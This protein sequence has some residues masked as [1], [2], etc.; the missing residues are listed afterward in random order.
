MGAVTWRRITHA[1]LQARE[2]DTARAGALTPTRRIVPHNYLV[3]GSVGTRSGGVGKALFAYFL[4]GVPFLVWDNIARGT[5][6]SCPS[7][8]KSLTAEFY[9]DRVLGFSERV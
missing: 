3:W 7:I 8:E 2:H 5:T 6:I 9:T 1:V 4:E